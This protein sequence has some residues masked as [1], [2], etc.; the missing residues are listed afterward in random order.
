MDLQI[1]G[2][3]QQDGDWK[4]ATDLNA[5]GYPTDEKQCEQNAGKEDEAT[6]ADILAADNLYVYSFGYSTLEDET[7]G[8]RKVPPGKEFQDVYI[9]AGVA[10]WAM[11]QF[12]LSKPPTCAKRVFCFVAKQAI[13][14]SQFMDGIPTYDINDPELIEKLVANEE[15]NIDCTALFS[16]EFWN[17]PARIQVHKDIGNHPRVLDMIMQLRGKLLGRRV[18]V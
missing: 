5:G 8:Y 16:A 6:L 14:T 13:P 3:T 18:E 17:I 1:D 2:F 9:V 10:D 15:G 4:L 12:S 11:G 7:S